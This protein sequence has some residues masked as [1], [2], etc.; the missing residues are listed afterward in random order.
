MEDLLRGF[1]LE[2]R[3]RQ[4]RWDRVRGHNIVVESVQKVDRRSTVWKIY[5]SVRLNKISV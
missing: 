2:E 4:R 1:T 3:D 5:L